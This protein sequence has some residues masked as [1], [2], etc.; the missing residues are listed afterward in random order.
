MTVYANG[1]QEETSVTCTRDGQISS[2]HLA[3][4]I[5]CH[6]ISR[7]LRLIFLVI[8]GVVLLYEIQASVEI[9]G[10]INIQVSHSNYLY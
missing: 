1:K 7:S 4:N 5:F 10:P 8:P 3:G 9:I 2:R 6:V